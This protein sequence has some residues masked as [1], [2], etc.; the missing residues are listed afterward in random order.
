MKLKYI[1]NNYNTKW[2]R[3]L[4]MIFQRK[5]FKEI[6]LFLAAVLL[7][8]LVS[9]TYANVIT[10][11]CADTN[12][13]CTLDELASGGSIVID[14][15][16]F[17]GWVINDFSTTPVVA[18]GIQVLALDD[19]LLNPGLQFNA[20]GQF[21]VTGLDLI[22]L[23]IEFNVSTLDGSARIKDSSLEINQFDFGVGNIGGFIEILEDVLDTNGNLI[24]DKRVTA[25]N[26]AGVFDLF[27]TTN[28][29]TQAMISVETSIL[30]LGDS[31][32]DTVSLDRFT[33]RFSLDNPISEPVTLILIGIGWAGLCFVRRKQNLNSI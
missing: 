14:D 24:G 4:A 28:F 6:I 21:N 13:S 19:Q 7:A 31:G 22:D 11:G 8:C 1:K 25:D 29:P 18:S 15:K 5:K 2:K 9:T 33:Q 26:T 10:N 30:L 27:D 16:L 23:G 32:P 17:D 3:I 20:N 12:A